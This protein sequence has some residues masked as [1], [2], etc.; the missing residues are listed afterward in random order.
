MSKSI[1]LL[2]LPKEGPVEVCEA[3]GLVAGVPLIGNHAGEWVLTGFDLGTQ[4][5][6][7]FAMRRI[8]TFLTDE[9][10]AELLAN[11]CDGWIAA[12]RIFRAY[13]GEGSIDVAGDHEIVLAGP[14]PSGVSPKDVLLLERLGWT[15]DNDQGCFSRIVN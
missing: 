6:R 14:D 11:S 15:A 3:L 4:R 5:A 12:F 7:N 8:V 13:L 2:Y 1:K 10:P 9:A